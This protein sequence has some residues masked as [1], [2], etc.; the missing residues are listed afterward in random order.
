MRSITFF[1]LYATGSRSNERKYVF[2]HTASACNI[3]STSEWTS[4]SSY[5]FRWYYDVSVCVCVCVHI[6]KDLHITTSQSTRLG[7]FKTTGGLLLMLLHQRRRE[8]DAITKANNR[9]LL[10]FEWYLKAA[11][12]HKLLILFFRCD[13][14]QSLTFG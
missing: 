10:A 1:L 14:N 5:L 8:E 7:S 3:I 9:Q 4:H 13:L 2:H 6:L 12:I 11:G